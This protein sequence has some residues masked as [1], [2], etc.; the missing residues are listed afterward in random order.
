[1]ARTWFVVFQLVIVWCLG[2]SEL[3]R[4]CVGDGDGHACTIATCACVASC[5]CQVAHREA[6]ALAR[7]LGQ[8][9]SCCKTKASLLAASEALLGACHGADQ[10]S[11]FA[12]PTRRDAAAL[13]AGALANVFLTPWRA[14]APRPALLATTRTLPPAARPPWRLA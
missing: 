5:T 8:V 2:F 6:T 1:M 9:P 7:R 14:P 12:P 4:P 3:P 10:P 13:H 11:H